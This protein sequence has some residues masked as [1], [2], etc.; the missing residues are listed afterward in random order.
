MD[1]SIAD[2]GAV[3]TSAV[4]GVAMAASLARPTIFIL[5][6]FILLVRGMTSLV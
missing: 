3:D 4:K 2:D 1:I 5:H 6:F